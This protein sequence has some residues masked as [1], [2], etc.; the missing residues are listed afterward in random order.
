MNIIPFSGLPDFSESVVLDKKVWILR[1]Q[2]NS[3]FEFWTMSIADVSGLL[4]DGVRLVPNLML[5]SCH[6]KDTLPAGDFALISPNASTNEVGRNN[7]GTD[8]DYLL[9]YLTEAELSAAV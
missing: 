6:A 7:L 9:I 1:F 2:W 8:L 5:L 3:R 4:I